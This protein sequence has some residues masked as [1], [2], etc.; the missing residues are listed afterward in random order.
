MARAHPK[1]AMRP[2]LAADTPL[3]AEIF[4]ASV[5]ELTGDDYSEAQQEAWVAAADD[6]QA[7]GARLAKGLT[8]LGTMDGSPVGFAS[9]VDNERLD[10]LYV[11]PAAAGH[12]VGSMLVDALEKLAAARGA[13]R[14]RAEV[15]DS[16]QDFFKRRGFVPQQR[17]TVPLGDEWLANTT[18][19]KPLAAKERAP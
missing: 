17:N 14:L 8:L 1:L 9:L 15:S 6:E 10:M 5:K 13:R 2:F 11:H 19:E 18:M 7:F 12:G 4:R 3:L 16:A